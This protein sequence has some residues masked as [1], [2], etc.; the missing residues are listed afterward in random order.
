MPGLLAEARDLGVR[1]R[2]DLVQFALRSID[3]AGDLADN[4]RHRVIGI[5][6]LEH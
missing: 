6:L 2:I 4:P 3:Y 1:L 5:G